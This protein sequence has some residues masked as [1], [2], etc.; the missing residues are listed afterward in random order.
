MNCDD[1][2]WLCNKCK[3]YTD[4]EIYKIRVC[5]EQFDAHIQFQSPPQLQQQILRASLMHADVP[6]S[7]G[8]K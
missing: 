6:D 5:I 1:Y 2:Y 3:M 7:L 8:Q 4:I